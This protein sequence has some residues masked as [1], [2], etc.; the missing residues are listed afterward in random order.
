MSGRVATFI[1]TFYLIEEDDLALNIAQILVESNGECNMIV[2][3]YEKDI[4]ER[5]I[6]AKNSGGSSKYS[7]M[8]DSMMKYIKDNE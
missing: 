3:R 4:K 6:L 8:F 7:R 2:R 5:Y 1:Y